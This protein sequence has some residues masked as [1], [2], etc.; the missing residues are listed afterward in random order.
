MCSD[1]MIPFFDYKISMNFSLIIKINYYLLGL[2]GQCLGSAHKHALP[3]AG[4]SVGGTTA[5]LP[6]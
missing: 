1:K 4:T 5:Q 6:K 3:Q 2:L